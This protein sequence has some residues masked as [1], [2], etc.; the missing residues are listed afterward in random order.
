MLIVY[1]SLLYFLL[2]K[3]QD[4]LQMPLV[5][6]LKSWRVVEDKTGVAHECERLMDIVYPSL[7]WVG[8]GTLIDNYSK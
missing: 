2:Q 5:A 3:R 4:F 7:I 6:C 8:S 1:F